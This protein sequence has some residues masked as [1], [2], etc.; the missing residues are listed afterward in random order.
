MA[1]ILFV[2]AAVGLSAVSLM[3]RGGAQVAHRPRPITGSRLLLALCLLAFGLALAAATRGPTR[4]AAT[5]AAVALWGA[6]VAWCWRLLRW[7]ELQD[8]SECLRFFASASAL[9]AFVCLVLGLG[10]PIRFVYFG[11]PLAQGLFGPLSAVIPPLREMRELKRYLLPAGWAAVVAA[12]AVLELRLRSLPR[13]VGPALAAA[14]L[15]VGLGERASADT[16]K[17]QL[18]PLPAGY[19]LLRRSTQSGGLL[20]LPFDGWGQV[21]SVHRMLWQPRHGRPITAGRTGLD[22]A[23][24]SPA[25]A[26]FNSFPSDESVLL[27]RAWGIDSV[28]D[29]RGGDEPRWPD[30]VA[31][32]GSVP[33]ERGEWRLL[34]VLPRGG[35]EAA[36]AEPETP[37]GRWEA[38]SAH[39]DDTQSLRATDGSLETAAVVTADDGLAVGL[40]TGKMP[41]ALELDYGSGR[42]ARVPPELRVLARSAEGDW[43]DVTDPASARFLRARAANQLLRRQSARLVVLLQPLRASELRLVSAERPWELPELRVRA[44]D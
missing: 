34:D 20:E 38:A 28:L 40:P 36:L 2:A 44:T 39:P 35:V 30:G 27:L 43:R 33:G 9:A 21:T 29:T 6:L 11:E 1:F 5:A 12:A 22:P 37:A 25:L 19:E 15:A 23:W 4:G 3:R 10:S 13:A 26:I 8:E 7:P 32:R 41:A 14:L 24:Y 31:L 16:R 17:A 42:F 18:P